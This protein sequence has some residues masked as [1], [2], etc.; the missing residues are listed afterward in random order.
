MTN[1]SPCTLLLFLAA[2]ILFSTDSRSVAAATATT[3]C[4][5]GGHEVELLSPVS[6]NKLVFCQISRNGQLLRHGPSSEV[7][8]NGKAI[9]VESYR[10]GKLLGQEARP[11]P[12]PILDSRLDSSFD[13]NLDSKIDSKI[14]SEK[15]TNA[16]LISEDAQRNLSDDPT[17]GLPTAEAKR[18][19]PSKSFFHSSNVGMAI[20]KTS[21]QYESEY[22]D[23]ARKKMQELL[24]WSAKQ[25]PTSTAGTPVLPTDVL[26]KNEF[27]QAFLD[28]FLFDSTKP[29]DK[30]KLHKLLTHYFA[31]LEAADYRVTD[32]EN[33]PIL[34]LLREL[35]GHIEA[36]NLDGVNRFIHEFSFPPDYNFHGLTPV[37]HLVARYGKAQGEEMLKILFSSTRIDPDLVGNCDLDGAK[38]CDSKKDQRQCTALDLAANETKTAMLNWLLTQGANPNGKPAITKITPLGQIMQQHARVDDSMT[39]IDGI[40]PVLLAHEKI[41]YQQIFNGPTCPPRL[42]NAL[43][44]A[45]GVTGHE[46]VMSYLRAKNIEWETSVPSPLMA[47]IDYSSSVRREEKG[48]RVA[49]RVKWLNSSQYPVRERLD[50]DDKPLRAYIEEG[51]LEVLEYV[52]VLGIDINKLDSEGRTPAYH[53]FESIHWPGGRMPRDFVSKRKNEEPFTTMRR[54]QILQYIFAHKGKRQIYDRHG[55]G[56]LYYAGQ[57]APFSDYL[58]DFLKESESF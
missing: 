43:G 19:R 46:N 14:A 1:H 54:L 44:F 31:K 51:F 33:H 32:L 40:I 39:E 56:M 30:T 42:Y 5:D 36:D 12:E 22:R 57:E 17:S 8:R 47:A 45:I 50:L 26:A 18:E 24:A 20:E 6:G 25:L 4:P 13:S 10:E 58:I 29:K 34:P 3:A 41:D 11:S 53:V 21:T 52:D 35:Q 15:S 16:K 23:Y 7:D 55:K 49:Q 38:K 37:L 28:L 9:K 48:A 27:A 2:T